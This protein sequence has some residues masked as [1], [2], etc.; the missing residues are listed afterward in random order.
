[1]E[2]NKNLIPETE[3]NA[4]AAENKAADTAPET[5]K[6][7][8]KVKKE[9]KPK[10]LKNQALL[11]KGSFSVAIT[12]AVLAG[13][14]LLNV[15]VGA[16]SKR[17]VLEFDMSAE[18]ENSMSEENIDY[19]K[20][21]ET[22]VNITVCATPDEYVGGYMGYYAQKLY[23]VSDDA[24]DY[25][26]QTITLLDKYSAYNDKI[27]LRYVDTQDTEF[28]EISSKYSGEDLTYGDIIVSAEKNE[29][30][31]YKVVEFEDIY[32]LNE[33]TTYASYGFTTKTVAGNN[34]ETAV[35]SAIA[36]VT[37]DK[38]KKVALITGH[39]KNDYTADYQTLL[40]NNNYEI[41]EI[42]DS[43][44]G[45]ISNEYDAV[46]IA[47]PT[48]DFLGS[49]LA[50]LSEFLDNDGKLGKGLIFFADATAPYLTN[51]YD[52]LGEWGI[53][54]GEGI[55]FETNSQ[56][57][58]PDDPMTLGTYPTSSDNDITKGMNLCI[59][60]YNVPITAA[61]EAEG[62][63]TVTSLMSTP[64][65]VVAAPVGTAADWTGADE[66]TKQSY[67]SVIQSETLNYDSDNNEIRSYVFAFSSVE[68]IDS[69]YNEQSSVSNKNITLAAA[70][71][72]VGAEDTGISFISKTITNESYA[73]SVNDASLN[74]IR[75]VFM[76][77][78]P[79]ACVVIGVYIFIR[80]KNA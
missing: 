72:A 75:A 64:E 22:E 52:F 26:K 65:S 44:I 16:L 5:D 47:A 61:F 28:T 55:M 12:A 18:K 7:G 51:F 38:I 6:K 23:S 60:G 57:Y 3:E 45:S 71:R 17:F 42:S 8:K 80:R 10:K 66:Y 63:I 25:Y 27:N 2:E 78:F 39:S 43:M 48:T 70:E 79:I 35:T 59:T 53:A 50:A 33:D 68:F 58:M 14:I 49:E 62:R 37:S 40:K 21:L 76:I 20:S 36:Y 73:D 67:S 56:N 24:T 46:I 4:D 15:L 9:K 74:V 41:T 32:E 11:R 30:E 19:I 29:S 77:I 69:T 34:I 1:M 31:H 13:I 54:M